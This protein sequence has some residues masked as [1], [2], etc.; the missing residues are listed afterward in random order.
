[1]DGGDEYVSWIA[2]SCGI[3][4]HYSLSLH[5][6]PRPPPA[7]LDC[8]KK[9]SPLFILQSKKLGMSLGTR[10][11]STFAYMFKHWDKIGKSASGNKNVTEDYRNEQ[12]AGAL[13]RGS[14]RGHII[15]PN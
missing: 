14:F 1:M 13:I 4:T 10:L 2:V 6:V 12:V 9:C 3:A 5:L 11:H 7:F 15:A 8:M